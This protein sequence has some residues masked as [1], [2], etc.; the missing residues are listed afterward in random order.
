MRIVRH[1]REHRETALA[2]GSFDGVHCGHAA[3]V[4]RVVEEARRR[5]LDAAVLT[6]EPLPREFF[7]PANAPARLTSLGERLSLLR[8][9]GLDVTFLERFDARFAAHWP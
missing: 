5:G 4:T 6:F 3:L 9:L 1:P 2:I 8:G 7:S